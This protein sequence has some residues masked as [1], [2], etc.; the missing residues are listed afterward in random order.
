MSI[1]HLS[2]D[3]DSDV[4]LSRAFGRPLRFDELPEHVIDSV[5][6]LVAEGDGR[7]AAALTL[8]CRSLVDYGR[9][10]LVR[11]VD[12]F[13]RSY[14][15]WALLAYIRAH[16]H[17]V[18][19]IRVL[20]NRP[21]YIGGTGGR[22]VVQILAMSPRL[23][24]LILHFTTVQLLSLGKMLKQAAHELRVERL[25]LDVRD[26]NRVTAGAVGKAFGRLM[27]R[28]GPGLVSLDLD[29]EG[30]TDVILAGR[31]LASLPRLRSCRVAGASVVG[32]A[33]IIRAADGDALAVLPYVTDA[34]VTQ[35]A[36][37]DRLK[38]R[39]TAWGGGR[40][41]MTRM[42][43]K[44]LHQVAELVLGDSETQSYPDETIAAL[45]HTIRRLEVRVFRVGWPGVWAMPWSY[46]RIAAWLEALE[47]LP[48]LE[49]VSVV[50][51]AYVVD[52]ADAAS[53]AR[54]SAVCQRR[55]IDL[56]MS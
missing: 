19:S 42:G 12:G 56:S 16:E 24:R 18:Q 30:W 51:R 22:A 6:E 34:L 54:L 14:G 53:S 55:G 28:V 11:S 45:P 40:A 32:M 13:T 23:D 15:E 1:I 20:D 48:R 49:Q 26:I 43:W 27:R 2:A 29:L 9:R 46:E 39:K 44:Q 36:P 25:R 3:S 50:N 17:L 38:I 41:R 8:V 4:E 52:V 5:F 21:D 10:A 47:W 7:R 37:E 33:C 31:I 35:L